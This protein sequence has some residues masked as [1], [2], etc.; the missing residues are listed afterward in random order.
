[1]RTALLARLKP[2]LEGPGG[3]RA[4][5]AGGRMDLGQAIAFALRDAAPPEPMR[6]RPVKP[7]PPLLTARQ[8]E[9][10]RYI[11]QGLSNKEI[12][13]RLTRSERTVEGHVE[14]ICN[15]LG[16]NSRVQVAA[17]IVRHDAER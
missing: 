5:A 1:M 4:Y 6:S 13:A 12:A 9:V 11:G 10:A 16:F 17:W 3:D 2:A 7:P 15:K 14:Q 8:L